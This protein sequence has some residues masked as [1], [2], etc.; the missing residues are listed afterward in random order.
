MKRFA[1]W[2]YILLLVYFSAEILWRRWMWQQIPT[3]VSA[4]LVY[5]VLGVNCV[6][7]ILLAFKAASGNR[8]RRVARE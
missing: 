8:L 3:Q 1:R 7:V 2:I 5:S 6:V 4:V